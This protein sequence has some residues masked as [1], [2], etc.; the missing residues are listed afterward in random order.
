MEGW[1]DVVQ[2]NLVVLLVIAALGAGLFC[3][4]KAYED[5]AAAGSGQSAADVA[6]PQT[7]KYA[8]GWREDYAA[9]PL[10]KA[11]LVSCLKM[12][13]DEFFKVYNKGRFIRLEEQ[14]IYAGYLYTALG[15]CVSFD[16]DGR[17]LW[18]D[19]RDGFEFNGARSGMSLEKIRTILGEA[20]VRAEEL[21][22]GRKVYVLEYKLA[23]C[24]AQ[25]ISYDRGGD[26]D[27]TSFLRVLPQRDISSRLK[28][29]LKA[30]TGGNQEGERS[31]AQ[32][33]PAENPVKS[34]WWDTEYKESPLAKEE[35]AGLVS[36]TKGEILK[37]YGYD[38]EVVR[39][40]AEGLR[41]GYF[42][43][44]LGVCIMFDA[45]GNAAYVDC[46]KGVGING[47]TV[48]TRMDEVRARVGDVPVVVGKW[49]AGFTIHTLQYPIG[50]GVVMFISFWPERNDKVSRVS[51][52]RKK[53]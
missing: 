6:D 22:G 48:G 9:R 5:K 38:Y 15:V 16:K 28:Q 39:T 21:T 18:V 20:P 47:A 53:G 44:W 7:N 46:C 50:E 23:D 19:C 24:V 10:S 32:G 12:T 14:G 45:D 30:L 40:G 37:K 35:L 25:F 1:D 36:M 2:R 42:Y 52:A 17:L 13:K 29:A 34:G 43:R 49:E 51:V 11:Q 31:G 41:Q 33:T 8:R 4:I 3:G 26:G 27:G